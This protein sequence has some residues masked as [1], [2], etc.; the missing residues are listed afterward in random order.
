[1]MVIT[2]AGRAMRR[3]MWPVY[4]AAVQQAVGAK[5]SPEEADGLADL[6]GR[7]ITPPEG[8]TGPR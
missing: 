4:A 1:M 7:L 3:R 5:L 6:L 2:D 8:A